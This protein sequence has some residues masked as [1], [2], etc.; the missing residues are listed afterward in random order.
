MEYFLKE[1]NQVKQEDYLSCWFRTKRA[2]MLDSDS[3]GLGDGW[4][5]E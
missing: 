3:L 1:S 4:C 5:G 2:A